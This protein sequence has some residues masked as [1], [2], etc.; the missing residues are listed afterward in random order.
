[1][2]LIKTT[3]ETAKSI[4]ENGKRKIVLLNKAEVKWIN[5][6]NMTLFAGSKKN[7]STYD[8]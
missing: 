8:F 1:M 7:G 4:L 2:E 5:L 3:P 6:N